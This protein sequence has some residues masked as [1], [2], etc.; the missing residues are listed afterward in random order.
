MCE[1]GGF[2]GVKGGL[3]GCL[4]C[5]FVI[6]GGRDCYDMWLILGK[7]IDYRLFEWQEGLCGLSSCGTLL[8]VAFEC[9]R[10]L[11]KI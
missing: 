4:W 1:K 6:V 10:S 7:K 9:L 11:Y 3:W 5:C 2:R 8:I